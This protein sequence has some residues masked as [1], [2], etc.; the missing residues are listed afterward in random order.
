MITDQEHI[1]YVADGVH[2]GREMRYTAETAEGERFGDPNMEDPDWDSLS[3]RMRKTRRQQQAAGVNNIR[4]N[5]LFKRGTH[6]KF[7]RLPRFLSLA[8]S[9]LAYFAGITN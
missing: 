3:T 6:R 8:R 4:N 9:I 7:L 2:I 5:H 1:D